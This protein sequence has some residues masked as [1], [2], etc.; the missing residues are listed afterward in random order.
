MRLCIMAHEV[1]W[2]YSKI[3]YHIM[4]NVVS[5]NHLRRYR[6]L[7]NYNLNFLKIIAQQTRTERELNIKRTMCENLYSVEKSLCSSKSLYPPTH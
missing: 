5:H 7:Y 3:V 4:R 2:K 6:N 1:N